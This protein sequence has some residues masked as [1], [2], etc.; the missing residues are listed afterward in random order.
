MKENIFTVHFYLYLYIYCLENTSKTSLI[1]FSVTYSK[2]LQFYISD[3]TLISFHLLK[4][5]FW[6][7]FYKKWWLKDGMPSHNSV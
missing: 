2:M 6:V 5:D 3:Y 7:L 1:K 4:C